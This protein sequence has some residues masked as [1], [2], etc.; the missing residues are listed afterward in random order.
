M[1]RIMTDLIA[2]TLFFFA[3]TTQSCVRLD[4]KTAEDTSDEA[5]I[6]FDI[7]WDKVSGTAL[8]DSVYI[9]MNKV[10]DILKYSYE[11]DSKG[12]FLPYTIEKEDTVVTHR[13]YAEYGHYVMLA[14]HCDKDNYTLSGAQRFMKDKTISVRD[15]KAT[16]KDLPE[17]E[18]TAMRGDSKIDFNSAY[19]FIRTPGPVW[20]ASRKDDIS[21]TRE[22][23]FRFFMEPLQQK[24][25]FAVKLVPENGVSIISVTAELS[26]VPATFSVLTGEVEEN[27]LA[28][29]IFALKKSSYGYEGTTAVPGILPS[30]N[31]SLRTGPGILRLNITARKDGV[32]KVLYPAI[33]IGNKIT[34][35]SLMESVPGSDGRR[36]AKKEARLELSESLTIGADSFSSEGGNDGVKDWFDSGYIDIEV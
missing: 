25:T 4:L 1:K 35:A 5:E 19:R 17:E 14:Y 13:E 23:T 10:S 12:A 31:S 24:L 20:A 9:A 6:G 32:T 8:P 36:I 30:A 29:V 15:F 18:L 34:S 16:V 27:D 3:M 21:D 26:G 22:N 2:A 11:T 33:N 28:R 7:A